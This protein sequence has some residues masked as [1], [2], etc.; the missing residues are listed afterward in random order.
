L[1]RFFQGPKGWRERHLGQRP[2]GT[3]G[4]YMTYSGLLVLVICAAVARLLFDVRHGTWAAIVMPALAVAIALTFT[5]SA[6]VGVVLA[7]A[8]L[9]I[10]KDFRLLAI[11]PVVGAV[12]LL[13][14]PGSI[15]SRFYSI[16]DL[17]DPTNRDR[18]AMMHEGRS[19]I[20]AH[21]LTGVGPNMVERLYVQFRDPDAVAKVNPHLHNVPMQIAAE[22][23]IPALCVFFWFVIR[24]G[25]DLLRMFRSGDNR[26][27]A[28][29]GLASLIAMLAAAGEQLVLLVEL[30]GLELLLVVGAVADRA[31]QDRDVQAVEEPDHDRNRGAIQHSNVIKGC[32]QFRTGENTDGHQ[33]QANFRPG[34]L[35]GKDE[36]AD[37]IREQ[38]R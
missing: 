8:L 38:W 25:R 14:A 18:L 10:L 35:A 24:L 17:H 19:M 36:T 12:F 11:L 6:W 33:P 13:L 7:V 22:R 21:P 4:H 3:L 26:V 37:P 15:V 28:A 29:T 23:G 2:Q 20:E 30:D 1:P 34:V 31:D 32:T 16:F 27:L 9:F 5:R